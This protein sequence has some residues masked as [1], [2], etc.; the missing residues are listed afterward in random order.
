MEQFSLMLDG[1]VV[2]DRKFSTS[3]FDRETDRNSVT[4][5]AHITLDGHE[6]QKIRN[7]DSSRQF[8]IRFTG[9]KGHVGLDSDA[10]RTFVQGVSRLLPMYDALDQAIIKI[11]PVKDTACPG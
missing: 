9:Q 2:L 6:L 7:L 11:G 4:E 5:R 1:E 10:S 8:L 3:D